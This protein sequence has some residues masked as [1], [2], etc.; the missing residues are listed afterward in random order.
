MLSGRGSM[1]NNPDTSGEGE[2]GIR[3]SDDA[4]IDTRKIPQE[5]RDLIRFAKYWSIGDD[6]KRLEVSTNTA[7]ADKK[8]MIDAVWPRVDRINKWCQEA[9][10]RQGAIPNEVCLFEM[11]VTA[12]HE[13]KFSVYPELFSVSPPSSQPWTQEEVARAGAATN[14]ISNV[15]EHPAFQEL[16]PALQKKLKASVKRFKRG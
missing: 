12:F 16:D 2:A 1:K 5:L 7:F 13:V 14:A 11:L 9:H 15:F 6:P 4:D 10:T 3:F 8:A